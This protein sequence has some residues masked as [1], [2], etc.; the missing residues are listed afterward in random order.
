[1]RLFRKASFAVSP[2]GRL[3]PFPDG[4]RQSSAMRFFR[5]PFPHYNINNVE[6]HE[7]QFPLLCCVNPLMVNELVA[8]IDPVMHKKYPQQINSRESMKG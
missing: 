2:Q 5:L 7:Q 4:G 8:Q 1:M 3:P 6:K